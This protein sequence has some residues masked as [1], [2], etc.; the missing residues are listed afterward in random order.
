VVQQII[1]KK[2]YLARIFVGVLIMFFVMVP[3][4]SAM[5]VSP[6]SGFP[7]VVAA[8]STMLPLP[9]SVPAKDCY[10]K[11]KLHLPLDKWTQNCGWTTSL[12][13]SDILKPSGF[14]TQSV[15]FSLTVSSSLIP[16]K[17]KQE[18]RSSSRHSLSKTGNSPLFAQKTA[19]L[20]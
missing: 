18:F 6:Q 13:F 17:G 14:E 2:T 10:L 16:I 4:L 5:C 19:L 12:F 7:A 3:A 8:D 15:H 11:N 1:D 20:I 9:A